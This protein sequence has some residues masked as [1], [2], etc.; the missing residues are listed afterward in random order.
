MKKV[1]YGL[2]TIY[3]YSEKSNSY[4]NSEILIKL[5]YDLVNYKPGFYIDSINDVK[6]K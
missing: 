5:V 1:F 4:L 2:K 3:N 6:K